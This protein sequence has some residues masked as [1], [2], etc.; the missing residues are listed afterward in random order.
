MAD[1]D[2]GATLFQRLDTLTL[3]EEMPGEWPQG[4]LCV[5]LELLEP[6]SFFLEL[7]GCGKD[8]SSFLNI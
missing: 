4:K 8:I 2:H 5:S 3:K 1:Y 6:R 7:H